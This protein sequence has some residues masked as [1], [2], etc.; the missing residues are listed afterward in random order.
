MIK[1]CVFFT[2]FCSFFEIFLCSFVMIET[3][4]RLIEEQDQQQQIDIAALNT[5]IATLE[6]QLAQVEVS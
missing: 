3:R 6:E 4:L 5:R 1:N 2:V